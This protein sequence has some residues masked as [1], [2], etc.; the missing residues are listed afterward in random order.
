MKCYKCNWACWYDPDGDHSAYIRFCD[1]TTKRCRDVYPKQCPYVKSE[2]EYSE[3]MADRRKRFERGLDV[4]YEVCKRKG[5]C[6]DMNDS[7][8]Y[9]QA[10]AG[11]K[12]QKEGV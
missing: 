9:A 10:F 1:K 3:K 5:V 8:K 6:P 11:P 4:Y 2:R 12:P 7:V